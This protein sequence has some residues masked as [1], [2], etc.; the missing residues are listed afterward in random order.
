MFNFISQGKEIGTP[1]CP[2]CNPRSRRSACRHGWYRGLLEPH[3]TPVSPSPQTV[4][5]SWLLGTSKTVRT[6]SILGC[7]SSNR[8]S[9]H[10]HWCTT[11]QI[12]IWSSFF[13]KLYMWS[14]LKCHYAKI[15]Q[16]K[17]IIFSDY[18][19]EMKWKIISKIFYVLLLFL[20]EKCLMGSTTN[21]NYR[22]LIKNI[23][24]YTHFSAM[25]L[26]AK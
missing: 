15:I 19:Y 17:L 22:T 8:Q 7:K 16:C 5:A 9:W 18:Y 23:F 14:W 11:K 12:A 3:N 1:W 13:F 25:G 20:Y 21:S 26:M 6:G 24:D 10:S 2:V 4:A